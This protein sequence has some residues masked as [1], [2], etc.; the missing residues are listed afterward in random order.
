MSL[1]RDKVVA[2]L[3]HYTVEFVKFAPQLYKYNKWVLC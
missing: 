2:Q 1:S 3:L